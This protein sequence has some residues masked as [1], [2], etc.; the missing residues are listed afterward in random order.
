[1]LAHHIAFLYEDRESY[2]KTILMGN[3]ENHSQQE[4]EEQI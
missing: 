2:L 4:I 3:V 1:M